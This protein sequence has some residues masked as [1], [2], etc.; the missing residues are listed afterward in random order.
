MK[1]TK[2]Q[3]RRIIKEWRQN[4]AKIRQARRQRDRDRMIDTMSFKQLKTQAFD[5]A[6][7]INGSLSTGQY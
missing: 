5:S 3:L 1:I 7:G 4:P 2:R 6:Q